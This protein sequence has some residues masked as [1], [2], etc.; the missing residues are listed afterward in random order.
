MF[1]MP[2]ASRSAERVLSAIDSGSLCIILNPL[3]ASKD[4]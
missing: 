4:K 2:A 1:D 3:N